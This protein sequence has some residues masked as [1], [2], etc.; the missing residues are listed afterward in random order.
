VVEGAAKTNTFLAA[1]TRYAGI[2]L[3]A[4]DEA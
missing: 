3:F 2:Q 1:M 4:L